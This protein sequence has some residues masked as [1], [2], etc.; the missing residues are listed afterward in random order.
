MKFVVDE[1]TGPT[2]AKWLRQEGHDVISIF[3]AL[4]VDTS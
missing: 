3:A 1:C 4:P 2:V